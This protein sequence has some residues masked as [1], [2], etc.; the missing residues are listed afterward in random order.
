MA[1][2]YPVLK[3][4]GDRKASARTSQGI[5][6]KGDRNE[7]HRQCK[8]GCSLIGHSLFHLHT[9]LA[10]GAAVLVSHQLFYRPE[11]QAQ[12]CTANWG[13]ARTES[14]RFLE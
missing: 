7:R 2:Y 1:N 8:A 4:Q 14:S 9:P 10:E 11:T 5:E 3:E 12:L 6:N 13:R